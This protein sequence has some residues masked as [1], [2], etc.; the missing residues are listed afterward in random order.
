MCDTL[1]AMQSYTSNKSVI[2]AKNSDREPDEVHE[3][4]HYPAKDY[5]KGKMVKCTYI[6][7]PQVRKTYEV[8]LAK[9]FWIWGCEMGVNENGVVIGNEAIFTKIPHE[10]KNGLIGMDLIRLA[11]ERSET[12]DI[13]V[14]VIA[15][16]LTKFGQGGAC[17]YR[18]KKF[19]Y[20]N[21]FLIA[22][23]NSA[24][25]MECYGR[26]WAVKEIKDAYSISNCISIEDDYDYHSENLGE[27]AT[28]KKWI[29]KNKKQNYEK[30]NLKKVY[31][32]HFLTNFSGAKKRRNRSLEL[33]NKEKGKL[34]VLKI[35]NILRDHF[36]EQ[37]VN[38]ANYCYMCP[39]KA[40]VY[41]FL[42]GFSSNRKYHPAYG[43][44]SD[45]CM[46]AANSIIR[47]SQTTGS[48]IVELTEDKK[49]LIYATGTSAPCISIF[50][51]LFLGYN[52]IPT[53]NYH[54]GKFYDEK[55]I[56]WKS[57]KFHRLFLAN[58]KK[59]I[60]EY[61]HE[62][63]ELEKEFIT[64]STKFVKKNAKLKYY[65][66]DEIYKFSLSCFKRAQDFTDRWIDKLLK[67]KGKKILFYSN[68]WN[69]LSKRNRLL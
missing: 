8:I 26:E 16:L 23:F 58:Y 34:D 6:E 42:K 37:A 33:M 39:S 53:E 18:D 64:E 14:E 12:S 7:I 55:S 52:K 10:K 25:V 57:E 50:K 3:L 40:S 65:T 29:K 46:H 24:K 63:N 68:Y 43:S 4:I 17:G 28:K 31:T 15:N 20:H 69:R 32:S 44:N 38:I 30:I 49:I 11:L 13:A 51:P 67:I 9:P 36:P 61:S 35:A 56:W 2:F 19:K 66:K 1:V 41:Y 59:F 45:I 60:K 48:M 21:S 54:T 47:K 62:R 22:D 27:Y 5:D